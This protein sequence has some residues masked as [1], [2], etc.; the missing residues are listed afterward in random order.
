MTTNRPIVELL[1]NT[2]GETDQGRRVHLRA[3]QQFH[4]LSERDGLSLLR[5]TDSGRRILVPA[6][7]LEPVRQEAAEV[8]C[9]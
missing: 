3:G 6:V 1:V 8:P 4:Y 7:D 5:C 9:A 2:V